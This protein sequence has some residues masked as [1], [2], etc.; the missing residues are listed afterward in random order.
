MKFK[1]ENKEYQTDE[2]IKFIGGFIEREIVGII[3]FGTYQDDD[4]CNHIGVYVEF[5]WC[6][7]DKNWSFPRLIDTFGKR[8]I[9]YPY[10]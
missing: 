3:R 1:Y 5:E 9:V 6:G 2:K 10:M 8:G 4:F 7:E